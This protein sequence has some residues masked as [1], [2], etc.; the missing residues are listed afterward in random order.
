M[1]EITKWEYLGQTFWGSPP[2]SEELDEFG[3]DGWEFISMVEMSNGG[4][5]CIFKRPKMA[6]S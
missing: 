5:R 6:S 3:A 1:T 2:G 4:Y